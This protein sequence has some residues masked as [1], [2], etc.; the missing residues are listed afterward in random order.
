MKYIKFLIIIIFFAGLAV[1]ADLLA[2]SSVRFHTGQTAS[3][4]TQGGE[5]ADIDGADKSYTQNGCGSGTVVDNQ[6]GLC[7]QRDDSQSGGMTWQA[8]LDACNATTTAGLTDWRLPTAIEAVTMLDYS[9]DDTV[10][11]HCQSDFN[12][13][14]LNW[15]NGAAGSY[16]TSTTRPD[17]TTAA[18]VIIASNGLL[19]NDAKTF[20]YFVRC[21]RQAVL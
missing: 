12:N 15:V 21:V 8:A 11:P 6:T 3:Y 1:G 17:G 16:W 9:C 13:N 10:R 20:S 7:W 5:D 19:V 4:E 2:H 14:A 18:Y